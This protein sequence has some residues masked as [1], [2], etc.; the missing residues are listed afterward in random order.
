MVGCLGACLI[1]WHQR[2]RCLRCHQAFPSLTR[3]LC[4]PWDS[5]G[6]YHWTAY[7]VSLWNLSEL[8][9]SAPMRSCARQG[10]L[11]AFAGWR[12][13]VPSLRHCLRRCCL[14]SDCSIRDL[15][16]R[17]WD[18]K[19]AFSVFVAIYSIRFHWCHGDSHVMIASDCRSCSVHFGL[20]RLRWP[21]L[22]LRL[23]IVESDSWISLMMPLIRF[24]PE[25][26]C[27]VCLFS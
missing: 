26:N 27:L 7:D 3:F 15:A 23:P 10:C 21:G 4:I 20:I 13:F 11:P 24:G 1:D 9:T 16:S 8:W 6:K 12:T 17:G 22:Y 19:A 18:S 25:Q 5:A 2:D 14:S